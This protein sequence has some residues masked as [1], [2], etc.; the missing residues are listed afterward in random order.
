MSYLD[1]RSLTALLRAWGDGSPAARDDVFEKVYDELRA[2]ARRVL[3]RREAA[4]S[5]QP[6]ALVH[7]AW[8]RLATKDPRDFEG[9][10]GFF[11]AAARAMRDALA[12]SARRRGRM[13]RGEGR[14]RVDLE[15]VDLAAEATPDVLLDVVAALE[16]LGAED[17][18]LRRLVELRF[19]AGLGVEE[20]A[21]AL[22]VSLTTAERDWRF[23]RAWLR[24]ELEADEGPAP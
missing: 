21:T 20:C 8:L 15:H 4:A 19:F 2:V 22:D 13:K 14:R 24:R 18:R 17:E 23:A 10:R 9:R 5:F 3:G 11:F 6:T 12:E 16:R 1:R 7:E